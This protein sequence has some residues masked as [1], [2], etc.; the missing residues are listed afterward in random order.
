MI[1]EHR[2]FF[3]DARR[4]DKV[5]AGSVHLTITSPPYP[6]IGMWDR[7]FCSMSPDVQDALDSGD[8]RTAYELMHAAL[9]DVWREVDRVTMPSGIVC[10]NI[11]DATRAIAGAFRMYNNHAR[12]ARFFLDAGYDEL[13]SVQWRKPS[14]KPNKF[15]GSGMLPPNAYV[16]LE[17]EHICIFRKGGNRAFS[18]EDVA[19]RRQSAYFWEERNLW[20][21]DLWHDLNGVQQ[22]FEGSRSRSAAFPFEIPYRLINMFSVRGDL[23]LDPFIGTGT[24]A[25]A[26]IVSGRNSVGYEID[27][28]I[29]PAIEAR[30]SGLKESGN[31]LINERLARHE[32]FMKSRMRDGGSAGYRSETYGFPIVT[33]QETEIVIPTIREIKRV[34]NKWVVGYDR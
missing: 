9:D 30:M 16:T 5:P 2:L 11:G 18:G 27:A 34:E 6:M 28:G 3:A 8:G 29:E 15:M 24:T 10:I 31:T 32:A 21:S 7:L 19:A 13:P 33:A 14:N 12:I 25:F 1:T 17:H 20:F 23:V 26:A 22:R 4:M